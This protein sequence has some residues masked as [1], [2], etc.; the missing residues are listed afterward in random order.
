M[1]FRQQA[2]VNAYIA[3]GGN[4]T[5]AAIKAGYSAKTARSIGQRLLTFVDI[6]QAVNKIREQA[7]KKTEVTLERITAELA[8][9]GFSDISQVLN[10]GSDEVKIRNLSE[11]SEDAKAI[12]SEVTETDNRFGVRRSVKLYNK[13]TALDMLIK[14][15]GGYLTINDLI[16]RLDDSQVEA[17]TEKLMAKLRKDEGK[18]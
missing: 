5:D 2:F 1:N 6:E 13:L 18:Q 12:I 9:V 11:L 8:K 7:T 14:M 10:L 4:A 16:D 15:M 3:N 17:I